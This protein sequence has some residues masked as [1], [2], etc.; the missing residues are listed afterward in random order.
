MSFQVIAADEDGVDVNELLLVEKIKCCDRIAGRQVGKELYKYNFSHAPN[1]YFEFS[2]SDTLAFLSMY[3][4]FWNFRREVLKEVNLSEL[5][6]KVR[7]YDAE[8][9]PCIGTKEY[10]EL[11][12]NSNFNQPSSFSIRRGEYATFLKKYFSHARVKL[13]S[14]G[15]LGC[16][17]T[18]NHLMPY[19]CRNEKGELYVPEND[20]GIMYLMLS[21]LFEDWYARNKGASS[22]FSKHEVFS[23]MP[24]THSFTFEGF[25][26]TLETLRS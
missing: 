3:F 21:I 23:Q 17:V 22:I 24:E 15:T 5:W 20:E 7:N 12:Q 14:L 9:F 6:R 11:S 19:W 25:T 13:S 16:Y 1:M 18:L 4:L 26:Y 8:S 2:E 10:F